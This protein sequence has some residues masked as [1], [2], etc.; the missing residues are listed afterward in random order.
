MSVATKLW[1]IEDLD[2]LD[3]DE[4][5]YELIHGDLI[6]MLTP[7]TPH[8]TAV[9]NAFGHLWTFVRQRGL[10]IVGNNGG[11]ILTRHPDVEVIPDVAFFRTGR[12]PDGGWRPGNAQVAPDVALEVISPSD[13]A[14]NVERKVH[15][16]LGAGTT[17]VVLVWLNSRS[18]T[19]RGQAGLFREYSEQDELSLEEALPGFRLP[20]AELFR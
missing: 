7:G 10:G 16:Y 17:L 3:S 20:V 8:F 12:L 6:Q 14:E 11:F 9:G 5:Q 18:V 1:T 2:E 15:A 19:V 4:L 13:T